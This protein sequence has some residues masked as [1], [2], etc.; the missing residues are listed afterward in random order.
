MELQKTMELIDFK[1]FL[2]FSNIFIETG[3]YKGKTVQ[4]A[5]DAGFTDV[6]SV[7]AENDLYDSC[8]ELF[9]GNP[10][11]KLYF[12]LS[13]DRLFEMLR[14]VR[15]PAV[16]WLDAHVTEEQSKG[17]KDFKEK[18]DKS[19]YHQHTCLMK[20]IDLIFIH[21]MDHIIMIDDQHGYDN[22]SK[23]YIDKIL[24]YNPR[25][26]FYFYD[27]DT[28]ENYYTNKVLVAIPDGKN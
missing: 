17:Y 25:Y 28:G 5:L 3:T 1:K 19:E 23:P 13:I 8:K 10:K 2:K 9:K 11:V 16:F 24:S 26:K 6:R 18:G 21:R 20:E 15:K 22:T 12:G 4:L 7:E 27:E 14:D